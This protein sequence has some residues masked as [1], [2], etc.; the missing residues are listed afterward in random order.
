MLDAIIAHKRQE[1]EKLR[2]DPYFDAFERGLKQRAASGRPAR[3]FAAAISLPGPDIRIIAE[4]KKASPSKGVIKEAFDPLAIAREYEAGGAAAVSVLTDEKYFQ[5]SLEHLELIKKDLI[6]PILRKDFI[7][8]PYQVYE[9]RDAGADA[10]LLIAAALPALGANGLQGLLNLTASLG[11]SALVEVHDEEELE[12]AL[13][14]GARI[15]GIN[16]RD[17]KTL[18][19]DISTTIRLAPLVPDDRIV[20]SESGIKSH[21]EIVRLQEAGVAAFLIGEALMREDDVGKKLKELRGC[22]G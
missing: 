17:L 14:S 22:S 15:I 20:V 12:M 9:S 6:L 19:V 5:G 13:G 16:N 2:A 18:H 11:M 21:A 8:D 7:I 4:V 1:I 10:V 3:D